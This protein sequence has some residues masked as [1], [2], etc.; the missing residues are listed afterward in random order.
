MLKIFK[1]V[2][3]SFLISL[4]IPAYAGTVNIN[5]AD[6]ET[7]TSELTGIGEKKAMAIIEY[8]TQNGPFKSAEDLVLVKGIGDN[9]VEKNRENIVIE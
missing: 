1:S 6:A 8:R 7:L 4:S 3:L 5:T 2:V 9:T